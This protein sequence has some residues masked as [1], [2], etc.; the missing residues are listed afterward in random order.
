MKIKKDKPIFAFIDAQNIIMGVRD[1]GWDIDW[2]KFYKYLKEKYEV[3]RIFLFIGYINRNRYL[4]DFLNKCGYILIFKPVIVDS[5]K[6][7]KGNCDGDMILYILNRMRNYSRAVVV[8]SDGDFYSTVKF[9]Y[10][11]KKLE[12]VLSPS[13]KKCSSLLKSAAKER[14]FSMNQLKSKLEYSPKMKKHC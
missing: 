3:K 12:T 14:I 9:L 1:C 4:Y 6:K 5:N 7:I 11:I 10:K 13:I 8:T 2:E